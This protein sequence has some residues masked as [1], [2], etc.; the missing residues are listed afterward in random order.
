VRLVSFE[1][2]HPSRPTAF[3][4][5]RY[6]DRPGLARM[7]IHFPQPVVYD[8]EERLRETA[9]PFPGNFALPPQD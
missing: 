6:N 7:G 2:E 8:S 1:R 5:L 4:E 9:R 3:A